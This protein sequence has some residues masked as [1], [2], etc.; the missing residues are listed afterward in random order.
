[1]PSTQ[2]ER[3]ALAVV[4]SIAALGVVVRISKARDATPEPTA[5]EALA[6]DSQIARV[7]AARERPKASA[8]RAPRPRATRS[9]TARAT[10]AASQNTRDTTRLRVDLDTASI[11]T[12][13][14]LPWIGPSL[15]ARIAENRERC[16]PFGSLDALKRVY[17]IGDGMTKRLEPYV[18]FSTSS[19]P[20]V[21]DVAQCARPAKAAASRRKGRL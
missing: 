3:R 14:A 2:A 6:L 20:T 15:A 17:G 10:S 4:A 7:R 21:A 19:R 8:A 13:E 16:G 5:A 12:I 11:S 1:M 9:S 18:T